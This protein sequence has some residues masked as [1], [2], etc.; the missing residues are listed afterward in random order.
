[1]KN[2]CVKNNVDLDGEP[3]EMNGLTSNDGMK[4]GYDHKK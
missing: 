1:M 4:Y 3:K 2:Y